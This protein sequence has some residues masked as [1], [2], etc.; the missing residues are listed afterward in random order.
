[1]HSAITPSS[2]VHRRVRS[3]RGPYVL[4]ANHTSHSDAPVWAESLPWS[5]ARSLSTGVAYAYWFTHRPRRWLVRSL[6]NAFP[7]DRDGARKH[8]GTSRRLLRSGVPIL[9]FPEGGR[10][11]DGRM[12]DF[13]PGGA[14]LAIGVGVPVIPA[15]IIGGSEAM[16]KGHRERKRVE[17][18]TSVLQHAC[19]IV[20]GVV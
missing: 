1:M 8:S 15:A 5:Q 4:V 17:T 10:Q 13:K 3:V 12:K 7:V 19:A 16:T 6:F 9:V 11:T 2:E 20:V 18:G 14:A